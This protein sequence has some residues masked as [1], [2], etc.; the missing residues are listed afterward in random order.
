MLS[1]NL[2]NRII[3]IVGPTAV[4]KTNLSLYLAG[5]LDGEIISTD[6]RLFYRGMDIGTAKPSTEEQG[7]Y[8]HHLIDIADPDQ[9]L[10]L[11][12]FQQMAYDAIRDIQAR[13]RVPILVGG[14]GQYVWSV[15]HGWEIP[16]Q[17]PDPRL[18]QALEKWAG[19]IGAEAIHQ[20]L[21]RLDPLAAERIQYQNV[22]RT[23]R[24]LEVILGTG[25]S[26][27][28]Q[29]RRKENRFPAVIIGISVPRDELY[30]KI[31]QRIEEMFRRDFIAEVE[32]LLAAGYT[33]DLST[34]SAIGYREV[35]W[36]LRGQMTLDEVKVLM[37]RK[38][39][40]F[41]RRQA[42]WFK[43]VDVEIKWFDYSPGFE[44]GVLDLILDSHQPGEVTV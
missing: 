41:V 14:T 8:P 13:G 4:G 11:S 29:S 7:R 38:T 5:K 3:A 40:E 30:Q 12:V 43:S 9:P 2:D 16:A 32:R 17:E 19:E 33:S 1:H 35:I 24:A 25:R 31:D 42:N 22:R 20:R 26:F 6:S 10:S 37:K 18:R 15:L 39:R 21:C 34:M 36:Y 28:V 23:V 27:S 44:K